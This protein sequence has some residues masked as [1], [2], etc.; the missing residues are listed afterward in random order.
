MRQHGACPSHF[1]RFMLNAVSHTFLGAWFFYTK[2][3]LTQIAF[4]V[5]VVSLKQFCS[6]VVI[7]SMVSNG[8]RTKE[9]KERG[10]KRVREAC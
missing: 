7:M 2:N 4:E 8:S 5:K 10:R 6:F 1:A 3:L 9:I